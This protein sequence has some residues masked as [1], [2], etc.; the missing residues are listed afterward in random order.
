MLTKSLPLRSA[1]ARNR[2]SAAGWKLF[3]EKC[4]WMLHFLDRYGTQTYLWSATAKPPTV[5]FVLFAVVA[6][7]AAGMEKPPQGA[8]GSRSSSNPRLVG[9]PRMKWAV[10]LVPSKQATRR[11]LKAVIVDV[12][13][14]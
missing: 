9:Y 4:Q 6:A 3:G 11:A 12:R 14:A 1:L 7:P 8:V 5:T 10:A 13:D 2:K